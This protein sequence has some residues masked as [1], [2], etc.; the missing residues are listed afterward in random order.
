MSKKHQVFVT[1]IGAMLALWIISVTFY[2]SDIYNRLAVVEH[3][4]YHLATGKPCGMLMK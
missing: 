1:V 4:V 2:L 3:T